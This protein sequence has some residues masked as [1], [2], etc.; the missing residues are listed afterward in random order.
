[1]TCSA[2][3]QL[4]EMYDKR[5]WNLEDDILLYSKQYHLFSSPKCIILA[6]LYDTHW[7]I[8]AAVGEGCLDYFIHI[9]PEFRPYCLWER[10]LRNKEYK[11]YNTERLQRYAQAKS[12]RRTTSPLSRNQ[13][14]FS[15]RRNSE[16]S[17]TAPA[18]AQ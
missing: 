10:G 16:G 12:N 15:G 8:H 6:R 11:Y 18:P 5:G 7:Y 9:M 1:M 14:S 2:Y 4:K 13:L 17:S 3:E